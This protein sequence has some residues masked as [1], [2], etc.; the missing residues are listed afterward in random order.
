MPNAAKPAVR[1]PAPPGPRS[2]SSTHAST[3]IDLD[4]PTGRVAASEE[5]GHV[6]MTSAFRRK[7]NCK[8]FMAQSGQV[9]ARI[10]TVEPSGFPVARKPHYWTG[11]DGLHPLEPLASVSKLNES[12]L[13][14]LAPLFMF[15]DHLIGC[16]GE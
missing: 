5:S 1:R 10:Q 15:G 2:V 7:G 3:R 9:P 16:A 6:P 13:E 14:R 12:F 4:P 11:L 8:S